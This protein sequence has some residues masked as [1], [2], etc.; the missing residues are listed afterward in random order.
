VSTGGL[1]LILMC[2][3]TGI[4]QA[5]ETPGQRLFAKHCAECHADA[6]GTPGT[7]RLGWNRGAAYAVLEKRKDLSAEYIKVI[8]RRGLIEMPPF[9]PTEISDLE[10]AQ[11]SAYLAKRPAR[12]R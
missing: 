10:L 6:V 2:L 12:S 1:L 3:A 8:V 5:Q 11:L 9:R 7:Q 4:T